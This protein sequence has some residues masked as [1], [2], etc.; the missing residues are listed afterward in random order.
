MVSG[1]LAWHYYESPKGEKD[2]DKVVS[3]RIWPLKCTSRPINHGSNRVQPASQPLG[4]PHFVKS[5]KFQS[6]AHTGYEGTL[7]LF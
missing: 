7:I 6:Y 3:T 5:L 1:C 2:D 4:C